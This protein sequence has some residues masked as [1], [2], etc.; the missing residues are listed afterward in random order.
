MHFKRATSNNSSLGLT[1]EIFRQRK[2][3]TATPKKKIQSHK[4]EKQACTLHIHKDRNKEREKRIRVY[5]SQIKSWN[6]NYNNN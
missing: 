4:T 2:K 3:N 1:C 6:Y 5:Y